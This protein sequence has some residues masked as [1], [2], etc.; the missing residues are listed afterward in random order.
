MSFI[1][2]Q[3]VL[4]IK[5]TNAGRDLMAKGELNFSKFAIGDSEINYNFIRENPDFNPEDT[6]LLRPFSDD[7]DITSFI[8]KRPTEESINDLRTPIDNEVTT[9][10][11][12]IQPRGVYDITNNTYFNDPL[13]VKQSSAAIDN[14]T[15]SGD[16]ELTLIQADD[17]GSNG[18]EPVAGDYLFI[19]WSSPEYTGETAS[20]L[21]GTN[22][23]VQLTYKIITVNSGT[24]AGDN[25]NVTLDRDLPDFNGN[26]VGTSRVLIYPNN[27][28]VFT[29]G[30]AVQSFYGEG[31]TIDFLFSFYE[32]YD[33]PTIKIPVWNMVIIHGS[34]IE[35]V[36]STD[37]KFSELP[38][39]D[40]V[41][42]IEY[43]ERLD[44]LYENIGVIHYTNLSPANIYGEGFWFE[45]DIDSRLPKLT[46]PHVMWYNNTLST[47]RLEI[48]TD[49]SS[50]GIYPDL[51]TRYFNLIDNGETP[52]VVGK[53][54]PALKLFVIEDQELLAALSYKSN[55]NWTLPSASANFNF[56][57]CEP[58]TT[59]TTTGT[60]I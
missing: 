16:K 27:N 41:G 55:R 33:T 3:T 39:N 44:P 25:L 46:I 43:I 11:N 17:Y 2:D 12:T 48:R 15:V 6:T 30:D 14:S 5:L 57:L 53:V 20:N 35:G 26:G 4:S 34:E 54:F 18:N 8:L 59:T 51:E 10:S 52:I 36:Q 37:K 19:K 13:H 56:T 45:E 38:S 29:E 31:N 7:P 23:I 40:F 60:T 24:L 28:N 50:E 21:E 42:F 49:F 32:N 1:I 9:V 58:V 47:D 22:N